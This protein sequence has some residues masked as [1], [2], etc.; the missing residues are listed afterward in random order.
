LKRV[1]EGSCSDDVSIC[2]ISEGETFCERTIFPFVY[3]WIFQA[4]KLST[5][6]Q[7]KA[8]K[9]SFFLSQSPLDVSE[10]NAIFRVPFLSASSQNRRKFKGPIRVPFLSAS[11]S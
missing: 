10:I 11:I 7:K 9:H 8:P 1:F 4:K 2:F 3:V 5:S 6:E